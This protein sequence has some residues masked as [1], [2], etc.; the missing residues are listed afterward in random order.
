MLTE[1]E[2]FAAFRDQIGVSVALLDMP[3]DEVGGIDGPVTYDFDTLIREQPFVAVGIL[4]DAVNPFAFHGMFGDAFASVPELLHIKP[5]EAS[6]L[7]EEPDYSLG[8]HIGVFHA[9]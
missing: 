9:S 5:E 3:E 7:T 4:M 2:Q 6:V 8:Q 1:D